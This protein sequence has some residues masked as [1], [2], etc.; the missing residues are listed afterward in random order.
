[1]RREGV[2]KVRGSRMAFTL[3]SCLGSKS[4]LNRV[5]VYFCECMRLTS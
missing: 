2:Y 1:M 5:T 3:S 4:L